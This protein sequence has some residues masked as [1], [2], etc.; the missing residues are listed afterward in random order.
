MELCVGRDDRTRVKNER[1]MRPCRV[2][3]FFGSTLAKRGDKNQKKC[4]FYPFY[5]FVFNPSSCHF[6]QLYTNDTWG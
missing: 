5:S 3:I 1:V 4:N 2:K 6:R